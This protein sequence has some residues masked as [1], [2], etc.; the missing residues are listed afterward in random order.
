MKQNR[1]AKSL[2]GLFL[3]AGVS[4]IAATAAGAQSGSLTWRGNVDGTVRVRID[5]SRASTET[6]SGKDATA[7]R[8]DM[9]GS[10]PNRLAALRLERNDGRGTIRI[11]QSP[12]IANGY[13]ALIEVN[14]NSYAGSDNY[15]FRLTWS[16]DGSNTGGGNGG[17]NG[18]NGGGE[19]GSLQER[20]QQRGRDDGAEDRRRGLSNNPRRH[21]DRYDY[22]T[23]QSY[24]RGYQN[25]FTFGSGGGNNGDN[26]D[27]A[28]RRGEDA[29]IADR[30]RG[31]SN[32]YRRHREDYSG[33]TEN[34]FRRGYNRGY[35]SA[36]P[37][38]PEPPAGTAEALFYN[39]GKR[40]GQDDRRNNRREDYRNPWRSYQRS[41][42]SEFLRGYRVGTD[43]AF[44]NPNGV[45]RPVPDPY[46][47][48]ST[49]VAGFRFAQQDFLD[50]RN[51][52]GERRLRDYMR[53]AERS[54]RE[55]YE[56]GY[57]GMGIRPL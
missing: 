27:V 40:A 11:S 33:R 34:S 8:A 23:E 42:E 2:T 18:G 53:N 43:E 16:T 17:N 30:Q 1:I 10:L 25:G 36:T 9:D 15:S 45:R 29:G 19:S 54:Y 49:Y 50:N 4:V 22:R 37:S 57:R 46:R 3:A 44:R 26:Q 38:R 12:N 14:D 41:A 7:V 21:S 28:F 31:Y 47:A 6:V 32:D 56:V 55:G 5:G 48:D 35:D 24:M 52:D 51:T 13:V 39:A 20:A